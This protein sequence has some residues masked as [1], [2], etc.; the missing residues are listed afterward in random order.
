M[1]NGAASTLPAVDALPDAD[2]DH[3]TAFA[4]QGRS[5]LVPVAA[6]ILIMRAVDLFWIVGPERSPAQFSVHW[7]DI[8]LP[9][10]FGC[11]WVALYIRRMEG[12]SLLPT[13]GDE[14]AAPEGIRPEFG[15]VKPPGGTTHERPAVS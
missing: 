3:A 4:D 2:R 8:V 14:G 1:A 15:V 7:L 6:S 11:I 12:R 10:T 5:R 9:V 13:Y